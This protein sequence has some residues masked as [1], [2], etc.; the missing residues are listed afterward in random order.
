M[1]TK[2]LSVCF[3][4]SD[5]Q[6]YILQN[7]ILN[8]YKTVFYNPSNFTFVNT[9]LTKLSKSIKSKLNHLESIISLLKINAENHEK[10]L[11]NN[12]EE[13]DYTRNEYYSIVNELD[14][15]SKYHEDLIEFNNILITEYP[16]INAS[17]IIITKKITVFGDS[18]LE[19]I[20]RIF[21]ERS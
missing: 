19:V 14:N 12:T 10:N 13:I 5:Y 6:K 21:S 15:S 4:E 8:Y 7:E 17:P 18:N 16:F 1:E 2:V 11:A 20:K 9:K 3:L